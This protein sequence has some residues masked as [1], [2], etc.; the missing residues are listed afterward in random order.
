VRTPFTVD[1]IRHGPG[2]TTSSSGGV[3]RTDSGNVEETI[4]AGSRSSGTAAKS[5]AASAAAMSARIRSAPPA[6]RE[7]ERQR[8]QRQGAERR[9]GRAGCRRARA[10][11]EVLADLVLGG[12]LQ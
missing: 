12:H 2:T 3:G 5:P 11:L 9:R 10:L 1:A 4:R 6:R 7:P 8:R